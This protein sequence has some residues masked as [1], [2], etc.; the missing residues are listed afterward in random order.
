MFA[1]MAFLMSPSAVAASNV[2]YASNI[3]DFNGNYGYGLMLH[4][5]RGVDVIEHGGNH[6][7]FSFV[8]KMVP[9]H[10]FALTI[11]DNGGGRD[12]PNSTKRASELMLPLKPEVQQAYG[13]KQV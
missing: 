10:K 5:Y 13:N 9:E 12:M 7:S 4:N 8:F 3:I 6:Q 1:L 11:L 2:T